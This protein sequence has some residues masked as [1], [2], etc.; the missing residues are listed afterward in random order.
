MD[1]HH[2]VIIIVT[3]SSKCYTE[4]IAHHLIGE[5]TRM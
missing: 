1:H 2:L 5:E 4:Y 3:S